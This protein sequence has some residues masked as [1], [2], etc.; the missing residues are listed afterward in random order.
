MQNTVGVGAYGSFASLFSFSIIF[1]IFL[2][3]GIT[4][5]NSRNIARHSQLLRK[6]FSNIVVLKV[7]LGVVYSIVCVVFALLTDW[8]PNEFYIL[9]FLILNQ[10]LLAFILYL[11]S[12]LAGLH[13]FKTDSV[14]SVTDRAIMIILCGYLL[15]N[16]VTKAHFKIEW[17]VY[18]QTIGY[19]MSFIITFFIVL[20]KAQFFRIKFDKKFMFLILKQTFPYALL[21]LFMAIYMRTDM[22]MVEQLLPDGDH[23][24]G[25]YAQ[26][27]RILDAVA[28][29]AYLFATLLLPIFSRML[30]NKENV[31]QLLRMSFLLLI[32]PVVLF[33]LTSFFFS[34]EFMK[35][36]YHEGFEESAMVYKILIL[37]FIPIATTYIFG[38]LLTANNSLK[39]LNIV[40]ASGVFVNIILNLILIPH[41]KALGAAFASV[42]TQ[43][44]TTLIQVFLAVRI[45]NLKTDFKILGSIFTFVVL[46]ILLNVL[47]KPIIDNWIVA[48]FLIFTIGFAIAFVL[49]VINLRDIFALLKSRDKL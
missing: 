12:N 5:F 18:V 34:D 44:I 21:V 22:V 8:G 19:A 28:M 17:F 31:S 49:R 42:I 36:L 43:S 23:Y 30:K 13:L 33:S 4:N 40:S 14:I 3:L 1:N 6:Y 45:F 2:D 35:L 41:Y 39:M 24:A 20:R 10:F 32:V 7:L 27:Y 11:R 25:I 37:S 9:L 48:V 47:L 29:Y 26:S 46:V 38:T 15:L 16:P